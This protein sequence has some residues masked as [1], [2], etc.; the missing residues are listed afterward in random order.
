MD[1]TPALAVGHP[2]IDKQHQRLVEIL[3]QV[4][5]NMNKPD[6]KAALQDAFGKL[7]DYTIM[8]FTMEEKL[9]AEHRYPDAV[10]HKRIH[11]ELVA[12]VRELSAD[13]NAGKQ[14][15]GSKTLFFLQGWLR[16]HFKRTD[17]ALADYLNAR[18]KA[19]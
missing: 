7:A 15:I 2:L 1:W 10:E 9:M 4:V 17:K 19:A 18:Q 14:M 6:G 5:A 12:K 8:H 11:A 16:D 13:L 3:N